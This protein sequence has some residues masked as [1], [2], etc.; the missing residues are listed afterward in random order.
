M[1]TDIHCEG[2]T[3]DYA[4]VLVGSGTNGYF[5]VSSTTLGNHLPFIPK[6]SSMKT[7]LGFLRSK[8]IFQG[9]PIPFG[10]KLVVKVP[11]SQHISIVYDEYDKDDMKEEMQN[12]KKC[13]E[14]IFVNYGTTLA[15]VNTATD[16]AINTSLMPKE[17]SKFP[18]G[19][20]C[21]GNVKMEILGV[22]YSSRGADDGS[23]AANY[24][25]TK[26]LKL[27]KDRDTLFDKD[28]NGLMAHG[29]TVGTGGTFE[30]ENGY[31]I[32]GENTDL[33]NKEPLMFAE[34]ISF[35]PGQE[36]DS[37]WTTEVHTT[38]GTLAIIETE[39][40]YIMRMTS[41]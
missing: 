4:T 33:Y 13:K 10:D 27:I 7:I 41:I 19:E 39:I 5:R 3:T 37:Y 29:L 30:A 25:H 24:V 31:D 28:L 14:L 22:C 11:T 16:T 17:F 40:S 6:S 35:V 1:V 36:I 21:P 38:A 20:A 26:Y 18:Y 8:G 12:G 34:P 15:A 23:T 2:K 9:Y 32:G